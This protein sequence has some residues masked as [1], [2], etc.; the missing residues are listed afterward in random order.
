MLY[1]QVNRSTGD[2]S[3]VVHQM[4]LNALDEGERDIWG[5]MSSEASSSYNDVTLSA[6]FVLSFATGFA[7]LHL[8]GGVSQ[9]GFYYEPFGVRV[10]A[11]SYLPSSWQNLV[12][13]GADG[14][15]RNVI[16]RSLYPL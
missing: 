8:S 14:R 5:A 11:S 2:H 3:V 12:V 15:T 1:A 9:S 7:G 4:I 13:T 16:N 10:H 6:L